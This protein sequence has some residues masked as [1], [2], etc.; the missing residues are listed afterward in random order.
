M[1]K[2][3]RVAAIHDLSGVG[4]CSLTVILPILSSMGVQACPV[5]TAIF[6]THTGGFGTVEM[7]DLSDFMNS[8]LAHYKKLN[9]DFDC[10]YS[11]FLASEEQI[12]H[13][14]SFFDSYKNSFKVVDPVMGDNGKRYKTYTDELC[15]RMGELVKI[16]DLITPNLTEA[17][18]LL[19]DEY[20]TGFITSS[21]A[22][23]LL[24]RLSELGPDMVVVTGVEMADGKYNIG[25]EKAHSSYWKTL[26]DY[27]PVHYPGTG[28]VFASVVV[29][30]ILK[31]DSLPIAMCRATEFTELAAKTTYSYSADSREGI[32][33]ESCLGWLTSNQILS[34]YSP[35]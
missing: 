12:D 8:A 2:I 6:S 5:P 23:S 30:G 32:M 10:I 13:C 19:G 26:C 16:A 7:R 22:K 31:N 27:V 33:L 14:L 20:K 21:Q 29:G 18:I 34:N 3:K 28:D 35:L 4:R 25:Y 11:G 24:S 9:I 1:N 17:A 15:R